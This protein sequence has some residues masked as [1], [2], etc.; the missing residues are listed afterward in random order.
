MAMSNKRERGA[1][2]SN[3]NVNQPPLIFSSFKNDRKLM[4]DAQEVEVESLAATR[5]TRGVIII[6]IIN[7]HH[8]KVNVSD[9][10]VP[11]VERTNTSPLRAHSRFFI[12]INI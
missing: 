2:P 10:R 6:I 11:S 5:R 1:F 4:I 12:F 7:L 8:Q 3:P 9:Y